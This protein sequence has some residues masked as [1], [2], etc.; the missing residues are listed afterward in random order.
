MLY[1]SR[2]STDL[3]YSAHHCAKQQARVVGTL[4][5]QLSPVDAYTVA[6]VKITRHYS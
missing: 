3:V 6:H 5:C 1:V 4:L 2:A